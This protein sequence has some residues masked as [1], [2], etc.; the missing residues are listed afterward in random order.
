[1]KT[2]PGPPDLFRRSPVSPP[3]GARRLSWPRAVAAGAALA[4]FAA[5]PLRAAYTRLVPLP[6]PRIVDATDA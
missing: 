4:A 3:R 6:A 2:P 5:L 1:M